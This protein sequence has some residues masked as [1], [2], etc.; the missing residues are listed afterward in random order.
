M[1]VIVRTNLCLW[2]Q[3]HAQFCSHTQILQTLSFDTNLCAQIVV[4]EYNLMY[5]STNSCSW[6][7]THTQVL[8]S[9]TNTAN[10]T[11]MSYKSP[12]IYRKVWKCPCKHIS[13]TENFKYNIL[14]PYNILVNVAVCAWVNKMH[15]QLWI[16]LG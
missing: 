15:F 8:Y 16:K 3:T 11:N 2:E 1:F 6:V 5:V 14:E 12:K 10:S 13:T 7:Q 9:R 4:H